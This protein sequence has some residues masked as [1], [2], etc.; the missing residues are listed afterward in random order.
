MQMKEIAN[1]TTPDYECLTLLFEIT[2]FCK[3]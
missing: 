2:M 1:P 3:I